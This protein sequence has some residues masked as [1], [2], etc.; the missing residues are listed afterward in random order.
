MIAEIR[1]ENLGVIE[2]V[3][4]V[5]E[6][7]LV[8]LTGE[9]GAGK[10][11]IVEAISLLVGSRADS[12]VVRPGADEARVEGRF[13]V[14]GEEIVLARVVPR[15]GRSRAYVNGRLATVGQLAEIGERVVDLHGQ[16][17]HQSLLGAAAQREAL[18]AFGGVDLGALS[19]IRAELTEIDAMMAA[20]GGDERTRAREMDLLRFQAD[21]IEAASI[22]G[23]EEDASL[24][25]EEDVLAGAT[26]AREALW[27]AYAALADEGGAADQ[28]GAAVAALSGR[29]GITE[30]AA[31]AREVQSLLQDLGNDLRD[32]AEA[33]EEDPVRLEAIRER[34]QMLV[35]LRRKYGDTLADVIQF[36]SAARSR[37]VELEGYEQRTADLERRR[38]DATVRLAAEQSRVRAARAGCTA[39]LAESIER[40][41]A[42]LAMPRAR[43]SIDVGGDAGEVVSFLLAANPGSDLQPLSKVASGGELA[44][45][46]L[47]LRL[48]LSHGPETL[49]FDEVDAGIG[50]EAAVAVGRALA[51]L[52]R[53]HQ[54][55]VVTHLPQ[56]AALATQHLAVRKEIRGEQTFAAVGPL[57]EDQRA[58]ELARMLSGDAA[59][60][61]ALAHAKV[62]LASRD[63]FR[64]GVPGA[65]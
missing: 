21:E 29:P 1:I 63:R 52:G 56:V 28:V 39:P 8:A 58:A 30:L 57:D 48:V 36:G 62:L 42:S 14:D 10:T 23:P 43:L 16:H 18:D 5:L 41:L 15:D 46:M 61:A 9:T 13:V 11:M 64:E 26:A 22:A 65:P 4:L 40:H 60:E 6:R 20:L 45:A 2:S 31:R 53:H 25:D 38:A 7:G 37:L 19:E 32:G 44:R 33:A 59:G 35:D 3:A 34:R 55:L 27:R 54:V 47:A 17:A 24:S 12:A 50:G 51:G 49:V